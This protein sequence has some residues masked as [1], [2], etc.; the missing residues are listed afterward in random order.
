MA[1]NN[2]LDSINKMTEKATADVKKDNPVDKA[3][4]QISDV[5][6]TDIEKDK[7]NKANSANTD[8]RLNPKNLATLQM[9]KDKKIYSDDEIAKMSE[10]DFNTINDFYGRFN[11]NNNPN[12]NSESNQELV[13]RFI[14]GDISEKEFNKAYRKL[15]KAN[16]KDV[17]DKKL[18]RRLDEIPDLDESPK[19]KQAYNASRNGGSEIKSDAD[20]IAEHNRETSVPQR[21]QYHLTQL[22][23][24]KEQHPDYNLDRLINA[25]SKLP[26]NED[27]DELS[28]DDAYWNKIVEVANP[29]YAKRQKENQ[30]ATNENSNQSPIKAKIGNKE[31]TLSEW[32]DKIK[33][34]KD[35]ELAR[36]ITLINAPKFNMSENEMEQYLKENFDSNNEDSPMNEFSGPAREGP[37]YAQIEK[38]QQLVE[39]AKKNGQTPQQVLDSVSYDLDI[40][41]GSN[42]FKTLRDYVM[43]DATLNKETGSY[44]YN[45]KN[46]QS[47]INADEFRKFGMNKYADSLE[48]EKSDYEI[49]RP[50]DTKLSKIA[51]EYFTDKDF[52]QHALNLIQWQGNWDI[53][54]MIRKEEWY[55]SSEDFDYDAYDD[56]QLA[57]KFYGDVEDGLFS[58]EDV[59]DAI[60][61]RMN[62]DS[63]GEYMRVYELDADDEEEDEREFG[64]AEWDNRLGVEKDEDYERSYGPSRDEDEEVESNWYDNLQDNEYT[65]EYRDDALKVAP[66]R[67]NLIVNSM[68]EY[69]DEKPVRGFIS[70]DQIKRYTAKL[71]LDKLSDEEL[72]QMLKDIDDIGGLLAHGT[73]Y[74]QGGRE[75]DDAR[76]AFVELVNNEARNRRGGKTRED[77]IRKITEMARSIEQYDA[78]DARGYLTRSQADFIE[79]AVNKYNITKDELRKISRIFNP[80]EYGQFGK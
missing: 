19:N 18:Q 80:G 29:S 75:L 41:P 37:S 45:A 31:F 16:R 12:I 58:G 50:N 40:E 61:K 49:A 76:S 6:V 51:D 4:E 20:I 5:S 36:E 57:E 7:A 72:S 62:D 68:R 30:Q 48:K 23:K 66:E 52:T 70:N 2:L 64:P 10:Q 54:D 17:R 32:I 11:K 38:M 77:A 22:A 71:G 25:Y 47:Q 56:S 26:N 42:E 63:V 35:P 43:K 78:D 34:S 59:F 14:K 27:F 44:E 13:E 3:K 55:G 39:N 69:V 21:Q 79:Q 74:Q 67:Q 1:N 24:F 60:T 73:S 8:W 28:D 9:I 46:N 15:D 53:A 33:T 65:R